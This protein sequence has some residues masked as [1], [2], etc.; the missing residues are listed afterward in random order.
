MFDVVY[1]DGQYWV[2]NN[3]GV[4]YGPYQQ[5]AAA[6]EVA[7]EMNLLTLNEQFNSECG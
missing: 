6:E 5:A 2:D 1:T 3:K 4:C 7:G